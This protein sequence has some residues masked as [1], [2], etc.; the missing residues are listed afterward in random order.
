MAIV[1]F[2]FTKIS[3]ENKGSFKPNEK[4]SSDLK[5]NDVVAEKTGVE[6]SKDV[7]KFIFEFSIDYAGSG[8]AL[9]TG[10]V[11]YRM[12]LQRLRKFLST[13]KRTGR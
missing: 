8:T 12:N 1:G 9:F 3:I 5:V 11:I 6:E 2:N 7:V 4:I 10:E 13:G